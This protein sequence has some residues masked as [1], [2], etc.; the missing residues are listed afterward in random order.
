MG[1]QTAGNDLPVVTTPLVTETGW[2]WPAGALGGGLAVVA[3][4]AI[5]LNMASTATPDALT[6]GSIPALSSPSVNTA[7]GLAD[8][9]TTTSFE[10][11]SS[12]EAAAGTALERQTRP[13]P[14]QDQ[15]VAV[16]PA[17]GIAPSSPSS[18]TTTLPTAQA[19][20]AEATEAVDQELLLAD[21]APGMLG[22][23]GP[24]VYAAKDVD[25]LLGSFVAVDNL[26]LTSAKALDG[27]DRV[28]LLID[29]SW[30][31]ATVA[32]ADPRT[33]VAV[34]AVDPGVWELGLPSDHGVS[35]PIGPDTTIF[36]GYCP[37][38]LL[39]QVVE[40]TT[41]SETGCGPVQPA[42]TPGVEPEAAETPTPDGTENTEPYDTDDGESEEQW[43]Y[44]DDAEPES[45][46]PG[47]A[48]G[49]ELTVEIKRRLG[50]VW[51]T[52][53]TVDR[54]PGHNVYDLIKT[55]VPKQQRMAGAALRNTAGQVVGVVVSTDGPNVSALP[56][57]RALRTAKALMANGSGSSSWLGLQSTADDVGVWVE[58]VDEAGPAA[59]LLQPGDRLITVNGVPVRDLDHL[60]HLVRQT[61]AGE[62]VA[63]SAIRGQELL[64]LTLVAGEVPTA[65]E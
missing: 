49:G 50:N 64:V 23:F 18:S 45:T 21:P 19:E 57:D 56:I 37:K 14:E 44:G 11:L 55:S 32:G 12:D 54:V 58:R 60:I 7:L 3:L 22:P 26:L 63:I 27:L 65:S 8:D 28:Y 53:Q 24:A 40:S 4:G 36:V 43:A 38:E 42:V 20:N 30:I 31:P 13:N 10:L 16:P 61:P 17:A 15:P 29:Q 6:A 5:G 52:S 41:I 9:V 48:S 2:R 35:E 51:S 39:L 34:L 47:R 59:G 46:A 1:N 62:P 25:R 33:D